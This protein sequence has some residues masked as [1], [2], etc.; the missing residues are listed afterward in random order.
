MRFIKNEMRKSVR[1]TTRK[2]FDQALTIPQFRVVGRVNREPGSSHR[3]VAEWMGVTPPTLTR[4]VDLL[5]GKGLITRNPHPTD[6]RQILLNPT[7]A[8]KK[9]YIENRTRVQN[10]LAKRMKEVSSKD[11]AQL[12]GSLRTL[13]D[14][15][16]S[17][18]SVE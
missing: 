17:T 15:F 10:L 9:I 12:E 5:V 2:N 14:L 18:F 11:L 8:G 4:M 6:K 13:S 3:D 1:D 16:E 7:A